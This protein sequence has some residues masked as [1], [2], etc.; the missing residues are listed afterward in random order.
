MLY[1]HMCCC[2]HMALSLYT[3]SWHLNDLNNA[4]GPQHVFPCCQRLKFFLFFLLA[5]ATEFR[6]LLPIGAAWGL[7]TAPN[8]KPEATDFHVAR[9]P[10]RTKDMTRVDSS[11]DRG[12]NFDCN[13]MQTARSGGEGDGCYPKQV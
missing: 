8:P 6:G 5:N 1:E 3:Q 2:P 11:A 4:F 7:R 10:D 13:V 12:P 9:S